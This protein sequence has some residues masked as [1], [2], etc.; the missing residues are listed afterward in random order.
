MECLPKAENLAC[1]G[2]KMY[3]NCLKM[4]QILGFTRVSVDW[5]DSSQV[6]F[7][8][9]SQ[10]LDSSQI[11]TILIESNLDSSQVKPKIFESK[12][13]LS[14]VKPKKNLSEELW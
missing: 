11:M 1:F 8:F 7:E 6:K 13:D 10:W 14:Q 3:L 5:L 2:S 12:F 4:A 9:L